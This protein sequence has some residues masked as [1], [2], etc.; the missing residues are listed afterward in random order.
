MLKR[1]E[2]RG[3]TFQFEEGQQPKGAKEIAEK[4]APAAKN[5]KAAKKDK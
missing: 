3:L 1:Y 2:Y 4:K 5:K